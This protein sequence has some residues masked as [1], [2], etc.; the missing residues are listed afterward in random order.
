MGVENRQFR[1]VFVGPEFTVSFVLDGQSFARIGL[2][3][4]SE[5]GCLALVPGER[6]KPFSIGVDLEEMT[7]HHEL[8]PYQPIEAKVAYAFGAGDLDLVGV[9]IQFLSMKTSLRQS[10]RAFVEAIPESL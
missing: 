9:G 6:S 3:N 2:A 10:L 4:I 1:R 7:L 5:G 8:L